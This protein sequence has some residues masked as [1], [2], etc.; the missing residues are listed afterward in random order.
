MEKILLKNGGTRQKNKLAFGAFFYMLCSV[1]VKG[2]GALYRFPLLRLAGVESMG[3]YQMVFPLYA[4]LLVVSGT[5]APHGITR[6]LSCGYDRKTTLRKAL[7]LFLSGGA[8]F[9]VLLFLFADKAAA[10]QGDVRAGVLYKAISPAIVFVAAL[11]CFRGAIQGGG[12]YFPT[13]F[14][15]IIEQCVKAL[16][17][18]SLLIFIGGGAVRKALFAVSAVTVS[19]AFALCYIFFAYVKK[20]EKRK[21]KAVTINKSLCKNYC[22]NEYY[23]DERGKIPNFKT[24]AFYVFPLTLSGLILPLGSFIDS[25]IAINF[26]KTYTADATAL[27][28]VYSGGVET[29][30]GLFTGAVAAYAQ[31]RL[32]LMGKK[33]KA[34]LTTF[35]ACLAMGLMSTMF[36]FFFSDV[37]VKILFPKIGEY[38]QTLITALKISGAAVFFEC[39]LCAANMIALSLDGQIFSTVSM[40]IGLAVKVVIDLILLKNP[41]IN[42]SGLVISSAAFY[43]VASATN[44]L[45]IYC[46]KL[47][48]RARSGKFPYDSAKTSEKQIKED[49]TEDENCTGGAGKQKGRPFV[50]RVGSGKIVR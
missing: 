22:K 28:G 35:L 36:L 10:L 12:D 4:L 26:F 48:V 27:Y 11:A 21:Q 33:K 6:M 15:Q 47:K 43:L 23:A 13:A 2:I 32:P 25:F 7:A 19:E 40:A 34:R 46:V 20:Y 49:E 1:A 5:G 17:S 45:Y 41:Q 18:L 8:L 16:T 42:V 30:M 29:V 44:L 37:T 24:L 38:S 39:V 31:A 50:K 3:L 14:S 9:S